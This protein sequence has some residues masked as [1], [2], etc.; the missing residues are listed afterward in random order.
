MIHA[1]IFDLD[2]TLINT[3]DSMEE[4]GNRM[5]CERG[6]PPQPK[7]SYRYFAGDGAKMLV[8]RALEAAG[9]LHP[10]SVVEEALAQYM[11]AFSVTCTHNIR[12]YDGILS[13]LSQLSSQNVQIAVL[14]NK[15]HQQVLDVVH[16][17]FPSVSFDAVQG[18]T[19]D[20]PVKPDQRGLSLIL[21]RLNRTPDECL[22]VG[23][24]NVDMQTGH[25]GGIKTVGV[26]WGFRDE[27]ELRDSHADYII[28][29]PR[30]LL[31]LL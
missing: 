21:Q 25:R 20:V 18:Q 30:E 23:D 10:E 2:G 12:P 29:H 11:D 16:S 6:L 7:D 27:K 14:S 17:A 24:T 4:A 5:L 9:E 8:R 1:V 13:M 19:P 26:L 28:G 3:I 22:Y 31:T 15:P